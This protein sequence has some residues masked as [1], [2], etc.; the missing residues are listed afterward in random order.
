MILTCL[1]RLQTPPPLDGFLAHTQY[2]N[3]HAR[4]G[5]FA[6]SPGETNMYSTSQSWQGKLTHKQEVLRERAKNER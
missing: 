1:A 5:M 2:A 3:I 6:P 4:H